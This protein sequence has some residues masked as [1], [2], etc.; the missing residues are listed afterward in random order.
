MSMSER[1][2]DKAQ[3]REQGYEAWLGQVASAAYTVDFYPMLRRLASAHPALPPLG[4]ALRPR[5]EPVRVGQ[6]ASAD[7]TFG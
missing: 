6:P 7:F 2:E 3:R 1:P 4:E 5:D